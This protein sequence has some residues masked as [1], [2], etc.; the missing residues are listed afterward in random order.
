[1]NCIFCARSKDKRRC[2]KRNCRRF[3]ERR[4]NLF[5]VNFRN[6]KAEC[7]EHNGKPKEQLIALNRLYFI[8]N[9]I[10]FKI[11]A[12][13]SCGSSAC[14]FYVI[15]QGKGRTGFSRI[16]IANQNCISLCPFVFCHYVFAN[17]LHFFRAECRIDRRF[18]VACKNAA[19]AFRTETDYVRRNAFSKAFT[20]STFKLTVRF[21]TVR[22]HPDCICIPRSF[23]E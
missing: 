1:M 15:K 10:I 9:K 2:N 12:V 7:K 4:S 20:K 14:F 11:V 3:S 21:I 13:V 16:N 22:E 5:R 17:P 8:R 23:R 18:S 19:F 6:D